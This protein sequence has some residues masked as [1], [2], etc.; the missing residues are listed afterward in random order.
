MFSF[1]GEQVPDAHSLTNRTREPM[2]EPPTPAGILTSTLA[3]LTDTPEFLTTAL[4]HV[5]DGKLDQRSVGRLFA[6]R[7]LVHLQHVV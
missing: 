3:N 6:F 5:R 1:L 2:A 4:T 7:P